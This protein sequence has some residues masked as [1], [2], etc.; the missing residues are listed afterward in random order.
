[1]ACRV[2]FSTERAIENISWRDSQRLTPG[3]LVVLSKRAD[4][5][6]TTCLVATIAGRQIVGGL[7][8]DLRNG[9]GPDTPP[10]VDIFWAQHDDATI[11][12]SIEYVMLEAKGGYFES[13]RHTMIGLQHAAHHE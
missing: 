10:R 2:S 9:E 12:P 13:L 3:K 1:V 4:A 5:F 11:D 6:Q 8:P 7:E